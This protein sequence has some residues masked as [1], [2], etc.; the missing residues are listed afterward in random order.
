MSGDSLVFDS[1]SLGSWTTLNNNIN[2]LSIT[3]ITFQGTGSNG[4]ILSGSPITLLG[5]VADNKTGFYNTDTIALNITLGAAVTITTKIHFA[6][7]SFGSYPTLN[8][9]GHNIT[10]NI[11]SNSSDNFADLGIIAGSG[12]ISSNAGV[13]IAASPNWTGALNLTGTRG[14]TLRGPLPS[15]VTL[16]VAN[17]GLVSFCNTTGSPITM[18]GSL[19]IGGNGGGNGAIVSAP[20]AGVAPATYQFDANN[21]VTWSG[22]ITLTSNTAVGGVTANSKSLAHLAVASHSVW[23]T[24]SRVKSPLHRQTI[25]A[26]QQ[27]V[28]IHRKHLPRATLAAS[29]TRLSLFTTITLLP[30]MALMVTVKWG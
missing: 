4:F 2:G 30:L 6:G 7:L 26:L 17:G 18:A 28:Y 9:N 20:C 11:P 3:N 14:V 16:T 23:L 27:T 21:D 15:T 24:D 13:G 22:P 19:S 25:R 12:N 29:R 5:S 8:L 1:T 10:I